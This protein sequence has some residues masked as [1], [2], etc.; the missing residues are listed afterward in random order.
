MNGLVKYIA[1]FTFTGELKQNQT[2]TVTKLK[3][4]S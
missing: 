1:G 4:H 2:L 3:N